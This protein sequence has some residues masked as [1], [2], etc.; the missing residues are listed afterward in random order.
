MKK[1]FLLSVILLVV[2]VVG[3]IFAF[4][5]YIRPSENLTMD[6]SS[7]NIEEKLKHIVSSLKSEVRLTEQDIDALIKQNM[8]QQL[9]SYTYINGAQFY[10]E[11]DVLYATL[12][13]TLYDKLDAEIRAT[14]HLNWNGSQLE[15]SPQSLSVK[16][17]SLP[18]SWLEKITIP[19]YDPSDSLITISSLINE[20]REI[21]IKL[22]LSLF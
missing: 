20:G 4:K 3:A 10:I 11:N 14:Y 12:N 2:I 8:D 15:L 9:N 22:K 7:I 17:I 21:I 16:D 6:Y 5:Q 1:K 13:V 19:I 18:I